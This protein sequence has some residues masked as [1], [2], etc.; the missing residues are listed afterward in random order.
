VSYD[1]SGDFAQAKRLRHT[2]L[3]RDPRH[4]TSLVLFAGI[5]HQAGCNRSA[6]RI[7]RKALEV[8]GFDATVHD[9]LAIAYQALGQRDLIGR[10]QIPDSIDFFTI[11]GCRDLLF[12]VVGAR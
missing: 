4:V 10:N 2:I 7:L 8:D 3:D 11:S 6:V 12:S 9:T 1:R 5:D